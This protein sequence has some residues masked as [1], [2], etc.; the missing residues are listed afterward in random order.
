MS[1]IKNC[2]LII[3]VIAVAIAVLVPACGSAP[4]AVKAEP[5]WVSD[6]YAVYNRAFSLAAVG[7]GSGR[8]NAEKVA[9]AN[10]TAIFGQSVTAETKTSYSYSQA[11]AASSSSWSEKSDIAQAVKT[12]VAM[13][14]L[15]GA[16]IKDVWRSP[17]GTWYASAVMDRAKT[18]MIYRELIEQNLKTIS[19]LTNLSA[20]ERQSFDGFIN[21]YRAADLAEA[22]Q[23]FARV[24]NVISPGSMAGE[25]LKTG[26]DYRLEAAQIVR[27]IPIAVT[28]N[29]DRQNRIKG[30]FSSALADAGFR[31]GGSGS[32]YA[33]TASLFLEEVS[34]PNT[35]YRW[36]RYVVD[37]NLIDTTTEMVIFPYNINDREGHTNL[38]EAE[39][40]AVQAAEKKISAEYLDAM[41]AFLTK[42]S[43]K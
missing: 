32:R 20:A 3:T 31:T 29:G 42:N 38:S 12:S 4:P 22:N 26:D 19:V 25:N 14:T 18:S 2:Y 43:K 9:L 28:V 13:D 23:V 36:I 33:L 21:Y 15:I 40:R 17:D 10:L 39:N 41:G 8:D 11:V 5:A 34:Y 27:N 30:A 37:A 6:P 24:R 1:T 7:S 16:E 35:P